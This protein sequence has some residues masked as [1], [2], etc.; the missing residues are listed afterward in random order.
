MPGIHQERIRQKVEQ[1]G[2]DTMP[3]TPRVDCDAR[4]HLHS[5]LS[6][7]LV[8][9]SLTRSSPPACTFT[10]AWLLQLPPSSH[11]NSRS[12]GRGSDAVLGV[13]RLDGWPLRLLD[14]TEN[15]STWKLQRAEEGNRT[16]M[17]RGEGND[18]Q[19]LERAS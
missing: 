16:G 5:S 11:S 13:A 15:S 19:K 6:P 9:L 7:P 4:M 18:V 3:A 14:M 10:I 2:R 1:T 8:Q 12:D 17:E